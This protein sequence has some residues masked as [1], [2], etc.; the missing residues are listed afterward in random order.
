MRVEDRR[1]GF[2]LLEIV[3]ASALTAAVLAAVVQ[4]IA[5]VYQAERITG[6]E[7]DRALIVSAVFDRFA[8]DLG[9]VVVRADAADESTLLVDA[10]DPNAVGGADVF[11]VFAGTPDT[12]TIAAEPLGDP[13]AE[14]AAFSESGSVLPRRRVV[15]WFSAEDE[16]LVR[17]A[18][19]AA[20]DDAAAVVGRLVVP[21]VTAV[22]I[23]YG[24]SGDFFDEWDDADGIGLPDLVEVTLTLDGADEP[25]TRLFAVPAGRFPAA[26]A[27]L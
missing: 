24:Q 2:T 17:E 18:T 6:E 12:L 10:D 11:G 16:G 7:I 20:A 21:E 15:S 3:I 25:F 13:P 4:A 9:A 26:E 8:A 19:A 22:Q 5:L 23:R 14:A 1:R 27:S